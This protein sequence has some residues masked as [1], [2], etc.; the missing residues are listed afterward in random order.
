MADEDPVV[1]L[2]TEFSMDNLDKVKHTRKETDADGVES[3]ISVALPILNS[4]STDAALL[5]LVVLYNHARTTLR[6]NTGDVLNTKF[7]SSLT[8]TRLDEWIDI[9]TAAQDQDHTVE[10]FDAI[11]ADFLS[12]TFDTE[13][14]HVMKSYIQTVKKPK[15]MSPRVFLHKIRH[16][17]SIALVLPGAPETPLFDA[18]DRK[19]NFVRAH[20]KAYRQ[21]FDEANLNITQELLVDI[22]KYFTRIWKR[23]QRE[24]NQRNSRGN[25]NNNSG[26]NTNANSNANN[27]GGRNR[28]NNR[29]NNNGGRRNNNS[30]NRGRGNN[31]NNNNSRQGN[32]NN[33]NRQRI[34][35]NDP[36]P[37]PGHVGHTWGECFQNANNPN[38]NQRAQTGTRRESNNNEREQPTDRNPQESHH[39]RPTAHTQ[40]RVNPR[41]NDGY[42]SYYLHRNTKELETCVYSESFSTQKIVN[43]SQYPEAV[44]LSPILLA[45]S[46]EIQGVQGNFIFK[47]LLDTGGS[48]TMINRR[49]LP[50][51]VKGK[52]TDQGSFD[53]TAGTFN[54]AET[55]MVK[56]L[57]F[58]EFSQTRRF[59]NI[60]MFVFD[61]PN[62]P[63]DII[64][65][66]DVLRTARM[67]LDFADRKTSWMEDEV[68]FHPPD[69]FQDNHRVRDLLDQQPKKIKAAESFS[70]QASITEAIY[71]KVEI[72]SIVDNLTHLS[73]AQQQALKSVLN[74]RDI[75]FSGRIGT[76][77]FRK[78]HI[79]LLPDAEPY[80]CERPYRIPQVDIPVYKKE[81]Q[82]QV[83]AGLAVKVYESD[84]A[85][86]GFTRPKANGTIRTVDDLREL[87]KR[88]K[89]TRAQLPTIKDMLER[90]RSYKYLTLIDISM[91]YYTFELDEESS[92][93]C[94][95]MT[96]FGMFR[97]TRIP[98]GLKPSADWAQATMNQIFDD[99]GESV[100]VYIDDILTFDNCFETHLQTV[101]EILRRLEANGFTVNPSK[102]EWAVNEAE[103][104]GYHL[105]PNG[106]KPSAAKIQAV[107]K[108]S[109]PRN[110]KQLRAFLGFANYNRQFFARRAHVY[111]PLTALSGL[112]SQA[113]FDKQWGT[114]QSNA[115]RH[116]K[117]L[118]STDALLA[119]PDLARPFDVEVDASNYQLGGVVKQDGRPLAYFSRKL[120]AS[121]RNYTTIEKELLSAVE[122]LQEYRSLLK[123][124]VIRLHTDHKNLTYR[125]LSS[126]RCLHWRLLLEEFDVKMIY[127]P[128]PANTDADFLSRH[129]KD[130]E[131][132]QDMKTP[133]AAG[134]ELKESFVN[135]P[136][137]AGLFPLNLPDLAEA[138]Q[139]DQSAQRLLAGQPERFE[140]QNFGGSDLICRRA[141]DGT[142]KIVIPDSK[143]EAIIEWYHAMTSHGGQTRVRATIE[144]FFYYPNLRD[145][146]QEHISTCDAC[147]RFKEPGRIAGEA[148]PRN[149]TA[150]PWSDVAVDLIGPWRIV[151]NDA[152]LEFSALTSI[153]IAT[154]LLEIV[155]VDEKNSDYI[156]NKFSTSW[157]ARYPRP[158][159]VIFDQGGE[160]V[161]RAFQSGLIQLGIQPVSITSKNPQANAVCERAHRTVKNMLRTLIHGGSVQDVGDAY[162]YLDTAFASCTFASRVAVHRGLG[163]SPGGIAFHRDMLLPLPVLADYELIRQ[164]KQTIID[165]NAR[166]E[167]QRR[168]FA[169]YQPGDE[170]LVKVHDPGALDPK[171]TGPFIVAQSHTN[172]TITIE[173]TPN[174]FERIN[175][176]R[177]RPYHRA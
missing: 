95:I 169:D 66:R 89:R 47:T 100:E 107:L 143:V 56:A 76:Y 60:E 79:D 119:Y 149:E 92:K 150:I 31:N 65:G 46:P 160:F 86:P 156:F 175:I 105:T 63:H 37:L 110:P 113:S 128:G 84:W 40:F 43:P 39:I 176:R 55:V 22:A 18:Q 116:A 172:G 57:Y 165:A 50:K 140:T 118:L 101:A 109:E 121:Q 122:T 148:P 141:S 48:N 64:F 153:D 19:R 26:G 144:A 173:R 29:G 171:T 135:V 15:E 80:N 25:R 134:T 74:K 174:V 161:G 90:L 83:D 13:D 104:M 123:G 88:I 96:P 17:E 23:E 117:Q 62:V 145:K 5:H 91:Q 24:E 51:D 108:L 97:R 93:L 114:E 159:R 138:Q 3:S 111:A 58:P 87:N 34:Q 12:D 2:K 167:N 16:L 75:L 82:R 170:V 136:A 10:W 8:G 154:T 85:F 27:S 6:W 142:W 125:E 124:G 21:K 52:P 73:G 81:M 112:K 147:Q 4:T 130:L 94:V 1:T 98:M 70:A 151:V 68:S 115:F 36:C 129:P 32:S 158:T 102:C 177:V 49:S 126:D 103:W 72:D 133:L 77:P 67:K 53:T 146:I 139:N 69:Y 78:F 35:P 162:D 127:K 28:N 30:G 157:L 99:I 163:V 61:G 71:E 131:A 59:G 44:D 7:Q 9:V 155:R 41:P 11:L 152:I 106:Y 20:P 33:G 132:G 45:R 168:S 42:E 166:R 14:W 137:D 38:R 164:R 120:S 54:S